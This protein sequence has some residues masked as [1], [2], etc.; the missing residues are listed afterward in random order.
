MEF[1][2]VVE[3]QHEIGVPVPE[4]NFQFFFSFLG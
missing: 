2:F 1:P 4:S 3:G